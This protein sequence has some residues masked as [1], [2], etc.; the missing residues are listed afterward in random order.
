MERTIPIPKRLT[1]PHPAI[2]AAR[3]GAA[4][5][6]PA[7]DGRLVIGPQRGVLHVVV[8]RPLIRRALLVGQAV[9][10]EAARRGWASTS[11][12]AS[13]YQTRPGVGLRIRGHAYVFEIEEETE[14]LPFTEEE[15]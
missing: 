7:D 3:D 4:G 10:A 13:A 15:I 8:S 2:S 11:L 12:D 1:K 9:F 6:A 14:T 5:L